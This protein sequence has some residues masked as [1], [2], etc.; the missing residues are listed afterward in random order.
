MIAGQKPKYPQGQNTQSVGVPSPIDGIVATGLFQGTGGGGTMAEG[1][2]G[3]ASAIW[4]YNMVAAEFGCRV[5]AGSRD[6]AT[7]IPDTLGTLG[8]VRTVLYFNSVISGGVDDRIFACTDIGVFD[9]TGGGDGGAGWVPVLTWPNQGNN[10]GWV[11]SLNYTNV[12]GDHYLL[13]ADEDNGYYIYD[14]AV[15]AA[16]TFTGGGS[17]PPDPADLAHI[18]EWN[19]R[20]WFVEK[21]TAR[22]WFL[23]PLALT[24]DI[25]PL[26][27]G[28]R[29]KDGGHLVQTTTWTL[30][31]GAGMDDKFVMISSAGD[32]LVWQGVDPTVATDLTLV[33][34]WQVG[35]VP[36]GRRVMSDWGGDVL[37][38]S[39][40]G[41]ITVSALLTGTSALNRDKYLS[42]NISQY[43]R[44]EMEKTLED[45]GWAAQLV[46]REGIAII[47]VPQ[48][49]NTAPI[50][51]VLDTATQSW[52]M[53]RDL[54]MVSMVRYGS[55][56]IFGTSAGK[57]QFLE[58][59][60][61]N[62]GLDGVSGTAITFSML[63]H[64][65]GL[66]QAAQWK[67]PQFIRPYWIGAQQP[68]FNIQIRFDFD[69]EELRVAPAYLPKDLSQWDSAIW[70]ADVWEGTAQS[71][72]ETIGVGGMGRHMAIAIRGNATNDLSYVGADVMYDTGGIL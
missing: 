15:W 26:D 48:A 53:F 30:D 19:G 66:G 6:F 56:F 8:Q 50:Q 67:R 52:S 54:D 16:G 36:E 25:T 9:I 1:E 32:V 62:I 49:S 61:D 44:Q 34:R 10:A 22:A 35:S 68:V 29:F 38:L 70:D 37:I 11:A 12:A 60:L 20:I 63:T 21:N 59:T 43:I 55:D 2:K 58:G 40:A 71:Y 65:S 23:D 17:T 41:A 39:T 42:K 72:L 45:Y 3:P 64:Y 47:S 14:G 13:I 51:F 46:P 18:S 27:A 24:G 69:V 57:V 33:G 28:S 7:H 4:L 31:D 5:R